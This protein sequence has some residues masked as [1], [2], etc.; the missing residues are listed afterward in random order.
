MA[1]IP[2]EQECDDGK[3]LQHPAFGKISVFRTS[4]TSRE[5]FG[6]ELKH[7]HTVLVEIETA[8]LRQVRTQ[9]YIHGR[10][11]LITFEMSESQ[12]ARFVSSL[13]MGNGTPITFTSKPGMPQVP[14]IHTPFGVKD[15]FTDVMMKM[16]QDCIEDARGI[17]DSLQELI[18]QGKSPKT[19]LQDIHRRLSVMA[20]NLPKNLAYVQETFAESIEDIVEAGKTEVEAFVD[21]V[22]TRTGLEQLKS[23]QTQLP[24]ED[25]K[26]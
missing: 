2:T 15:R 9:N 11:K 17:M 24:T 4:G 7:G 3:L 1:Q 20:K 23:M 19:K 25:N 10:E 12:W 22:V 26:H 13:G 18:D 14:E 8:E 21:S 5:L 16:C 6:S